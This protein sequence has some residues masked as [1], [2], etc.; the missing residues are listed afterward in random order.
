[1]IFEFEYE[2]FSEHLQ[3]EIYLVAEV[4]YAAPVASEVTKLPEDCHDGD[5][6]HI[7]ILSL[8]DEKGKNH[9]LPDYEVDNF[10]SAV[11]DE[12]EVQMDIAKA[13]YKL[14]QEETRNFFLKELS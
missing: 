6:G 4:D 2:Y 3:K 7:D 10:L 13:E 1:M 8:V 5:P 11:Q 14:E 9:I 12:A